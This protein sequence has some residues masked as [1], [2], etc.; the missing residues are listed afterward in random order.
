MFLI[1]SA[2]V[3][4]LTTRIGPNAAECPCAGGA[5]ALEGCKQ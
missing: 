1:E 2:Q 4:N 5:G 3:E